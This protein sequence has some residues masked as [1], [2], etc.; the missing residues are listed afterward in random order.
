[1]NKI[2]HSVI[3]TIP[4]QISSFQARR[5]ES[6]NF[7]PTSKLAVGMTEWSE[8][9]ID[10]FGVVLDVLLIVVVPNSSVALH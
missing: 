1:M 10:L 3:P 8:L 6:P 2:F 9:S 7:S 4:D 5:R